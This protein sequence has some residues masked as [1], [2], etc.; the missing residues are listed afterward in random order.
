MKKL[1]STIENLEN[2]NLESFW[3]EWKNIKAAK[4]NGMKPDSLVR[5][6][7]FLQEIT[8]KLTDHELNSHPF[9][10][11]VKNGYVETN[12]YGKKLYFKLAE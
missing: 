9:I 11:K 2:G 7:E 1:N 4:A 10:L 6:Y 12:S 8:N 5:R 3:Q